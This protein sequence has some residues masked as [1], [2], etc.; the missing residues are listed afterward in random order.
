MASLRVFYELFSYVGANLRTNRQSLLSKLLHGLVSIF[1]RFFQRKASDN[2]PSSFECGDTRM[3][4]CDLIFEMP[5]DVL[6]SF[7]EYNRG[8]S[9]AFCFF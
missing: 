7:E 6:G 5:L 3:F 4:F 1:L 2:F 8:I 9:T